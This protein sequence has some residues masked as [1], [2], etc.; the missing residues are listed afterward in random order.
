M[1]SDPRLESAL[2][3][4]AQVARLRAAEDWQTE[5]VEAG[6]VDLGEGETCFM[7]TVTL[8]FEEEEAGEIGFRR[9]PEGN[10]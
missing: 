7:L 3:L 5:K 10:S 4:A 6:I 8:R 2:K 1:P 9:E